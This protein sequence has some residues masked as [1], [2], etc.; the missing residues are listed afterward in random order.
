M[1][2]QQLQSQG[3]AGEGIRERIEGLEGRF[4]AVEDN[5]AKL[6]NHLLK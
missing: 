4:A 5:L 6:V 1:R 2:R 3:D